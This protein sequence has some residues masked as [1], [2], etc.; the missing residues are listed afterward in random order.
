MIVITRL[1]H[2]VED[3]GE[4]E[5]ENEPCA[6]KKQDNIDSNQTYHNK[7]INRDNQST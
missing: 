4:R 5:R 6:N 1:Q 3:W 7:K 2:G